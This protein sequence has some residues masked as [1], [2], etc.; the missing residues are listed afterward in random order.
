[1]KILIT[2]IAGFIGYH[3]AKMI[4]NNNVE[5]IGLD[6][7]NNYYQIGLKY[8]RLAALGI[9]RKEIMESKLLQSVHHKNLKFIKADIADSYEVERLFANEKFT[10]VVHLAAQAGVRYSFENPRAYVNSNLVGF[11]NILESC[12]NHSVEHLVFASSSSVYGRS[13]Q[14]PFSE[15]DVVDNPVSFYAATKKSNELMAHTYS[16]AYGLQTTGLRFFTVYGPWGRPDMAPMLFANAMKEGKPIKVFNNGK[17]KRDFTYIDDVV[18]GIAK[19][20]H[21]KNNENPPYQIFN[22]GNSTPVDLMDFISLMEK[23]MGVTVKKQMLPMQPGDLEVT[24]A[25]TGKLV[26]LTG[27]KP[28]TELKNGI[29]LFIKWFSMYYN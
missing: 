19:T 29:K 26:K 18:E 16:D 3:F 1:M 10:H 6:N 24:Y 17:M 13:K 25:D 28:K 5:V 22:I 20:M 4:V 8:D 7:I 27:Y 23:E 21:Y 9:A 2:G 14:I 12:K 11:A 15:S